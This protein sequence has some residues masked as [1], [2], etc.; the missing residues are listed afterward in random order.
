MAHHFY[1]HWKYSRDRD[2]LRD[3]AYP[4]LRS[5]ADFIEAM[6]TKGEEGL[7]TLALSS[8]PEINDNRPEAWFPSITNYDLALI[9][10]LLGATA[11]LAEEL[12][13]REEADRWNAL[14]AEF[15]PLPLDPTDGRLL[16][17]KDIPLRE[18]HRHHSHLMAIHPLGIV[19][20]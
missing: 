6:T 19:R 15:P 7:R 4:Y 20:W 18:S 14:L 10:W 2:F 11:E 13:L 17:A 1:M 9:R 16:V 12:G 3:R 8:S 5:A